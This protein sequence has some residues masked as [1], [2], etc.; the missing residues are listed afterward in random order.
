[1]KKKYTFIVP[2][3]LLVFFSLNS[4]AQYRHTD[5]FHKFLTGKIG[6]REKIRVL[7]HKRKRGKSDKNNLSGYY[8]YPRH[9]GY[10]AL[11]GTWKSNGSLAIE[12]GVTIK[13][14]YKKTGAFA[15]RW[16]PDSKKVIGTWASVDGKKS[17]AFELQENYKEGSLEA[18][19]KVLDEVAM[20]GKQIPGGVS[21]MFVFPDIKGG[22]VAAMINRFIEDSLLRNPQERIQKFVQLY[23]KEKKENNYTFY[24]EHLISI[25]TNEKNILTLEYD[26]NGFAGGAHGYYRTEYYSFDLRTGAPIKISDVLK[27]G[28]ETPLKSIIAH[29]M[30]L[31]YGLKPGESLTKI[32]LYEKE[33][34]LPANYYFRPD[35][36]AF[37]YNVYEIAPYVAGPKMVVIPYKKLK[38]YIQRKSILR[39][40]MR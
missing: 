7:L 17:Y 30:R 6:G 15:G 16:N 27:K 3:L 39:K 14:K 38:R 22:K 4:Q 28:Y 19:M 18:E 36:L 21:D 8:Y 12:E 31:D 26:M 20:F 29:Q 24:E 35:G 13:G 37:F 11:K 23:L 40:F 9:K 10:I 33:P 34:P 32:G 5:F 1:M 25:N 2:V